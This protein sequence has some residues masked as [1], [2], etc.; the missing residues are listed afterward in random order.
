MRHSTVVALVVACAFFMQTLDASIVVTALPQIAVSMQVSPVSLNVIITA[1]FLTLAVFIPVSGWVADRLGARTV[2]QAAIAIFTA[3]SV[4]CAMADSVPELVTG[5]IMQGIGGAMIVPVGRLVLL[6][7]AKKS[8][9]VQATAFLTVPTQIGGVTGPLVGGFL[10]TYASWRWVF[11]INVPIGIIGILL[12]SRFIRNTREDVRR[13][14]DW[15]GFALTALA[16]GCLMYGLDGFGRDR[17]RVVLDMGLVGAGLTI[18]AVAII[19]AQRAVYPLMDLS[20]LRLP[21]FNATMWGNI[22]FRVG[23]GGWPFLLPLL[24]QVVFGMS[25]FQSGALT[26]GAAVGSTFVRMAG[27]AI[28]KQFGF[29]TVLTRNAAIGALMI[30]SCAFFSPGTPPLLIFLVV[31]V[32]GSFL[33]L[34][35]NALNTLAYADVSEAQMSSATSVAQLTQQVGNALG[36]AIGALLLQI[37]LAWRHASDLAGADFLFALTALS[38][39]TLC[40]VPIFASLADD[41]GAELSGHPPRAKQPGGRG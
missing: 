39:L 7:S 23:W 30:F 11:L 41:A 3:S 12:V 32:C 24:F 6:R 18:A 9:L 34:Q 36:V 17:S 16:L 10:T 35:I 38:L 27:P 29:R 8:E 31:L 28:L 37:S 4:F 40:S 22:V 15:P 13:P 19:Y 25:A 33:A 1:Y 26:F 21:T 5:R 2:F 20:L 14:F